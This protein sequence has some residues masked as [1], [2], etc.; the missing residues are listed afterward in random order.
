MRQ[1]GFII[2][3]TMLLCSEFYLESN[4]MKWLYMLHTYLEI[5]RAVSAYFCLQGLN[6]PLFKWKPEYVNIHLQEWIQLCTHLG[7]VAVQGK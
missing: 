7:Q 4:N 2:K 5:S 1:A 3:R 6:W